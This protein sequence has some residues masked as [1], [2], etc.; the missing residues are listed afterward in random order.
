M[1]EEPL[2]EHC[3]LMMHPERATRPSDCPPD[4]V[5][6]KT[7]DKG[8]AFEFDA[9]A[10]FPLVIE[11]GEGNDKM[12]IVGTPNNPVLVNG[13]RGDDEILFQ[14]NW[15]WLGEQLN[16]TSILLLIALIGTLTV[17]ALLGWRALKER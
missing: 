7:V 9:D 13:G 17:V 2:S 15:I 6:I 8:G 10:P 4:A 16:S 12:A 1:R 11:G 14:S 3:S 5:Y